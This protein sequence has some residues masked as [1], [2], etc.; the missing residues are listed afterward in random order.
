MVKPLQAQ[1]VLGLR[2]AIRLALPCLAAAWLFEEHRLALWWP[3]PSCSPGTCDQLVTA[4]PA[5]ISSAPAPR[6][7][8]SHLHSAFCQKLRSEQLCWPCWHRKPPLA[9]WHY[10]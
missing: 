9:P 4:L 8:C 3:Y 2:G 1:P 6:L 10:Q 7:L 5:V